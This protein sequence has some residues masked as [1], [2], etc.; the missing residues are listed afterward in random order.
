MGVGVA[1][2]QVQALARENAALRHECDSLARQLAA[3]DRFLT[4]LRER[5]PCVDFGTPSEWDGD[6]LHARRRMRS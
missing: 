6:W 2:S 3:L 1:L 4:V 5:Y